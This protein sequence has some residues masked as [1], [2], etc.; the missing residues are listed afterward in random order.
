VRPTPAARA[1]IDTYAAGLAGGF[2]SNDDASIVAAANAETI[3]N[4][5]PQGTVPA[6]YTP[7]SLLALLSAASAANVEGFPGLQGLFDAIVSG[8]GPGIVAALA[9][10]QAGGKVQASEVS[11]IEA[12]IAATVPDPAW[13]AKIGAA[14]AALGRPLD[15]DDVSET[16]AQ[17]APGTKD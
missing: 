11:A 12:A 9:L 7:Q 2:A 16:R 1:W 14:R 6:G 5:S 3:S 17:F 8:N 15:L 10:L 13:P 4:P